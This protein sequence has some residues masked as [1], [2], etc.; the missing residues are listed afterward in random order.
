VRYSHELGQSRSA[1]DGMVSRFEVG[2]FELD[3]LH[4]VVV[5]GPKGNWQDHPT[6]GVAAFP[7][8]IL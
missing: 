8:M 2:H 3:V 6:D 5:F 4:A 1:K 7:G